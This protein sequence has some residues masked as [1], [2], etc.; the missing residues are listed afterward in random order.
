MGQVL[1]LQDLIASNQVW[2]GQASAAPEASDPTG[3]PALDAALPSGGWPEASLTEILLEADGIGE[4]DLLV[5][6]LVRLTQANKLVALIAPP[7]VPYPPAWQSRGVMLKQLHIVEAESKLAIWAMEQC[8]R[9]GSFAAVLG[10]PVKIDHHGL[11]RLQVAADSGHALGFVL[12]D[13]CHADNASPAPLRLEIGIA[14]AV[15]VRKCRGGVPPQ[16]AFP[17]PCHE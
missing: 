7:Y 10:W 9:S 12:R 11:R 8:L 14:R 3:L 16:R 4:L 1:A 6:T 5:P 15:N 2:R 17:I 13:K